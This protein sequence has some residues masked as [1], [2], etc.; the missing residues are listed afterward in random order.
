MKSSA[1][2]LLLLCCYLSNGQTQF[3]VTIP[4]QQDDQQDT[5]S[6]LSALAELKDEL[7]NTK[8]EMKSME[9]RLSV[10]ESQVEELKKTLEEQK[11]L[12]EGMKVAFS[13]SFHR[14]GGG[15]I[16]PFDVEIRLVFDNII[17]NIGNAYNPVTGA[18]TAPVRGVYQFDLHIHGEGSDSTPTAVD[19]LKNSMF[20][21]VAHGHQPD[22]R[23]STS[24]GVLLL[25]EVGD[26]ITLKMPS[27][28]S[29]YGDVYRVTTFSGHL[30]FLM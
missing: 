1:F 30:L 7:R 17:T 8:T 6:V 29:V 15:K 10:S 28:R 20:I 24:N 19:L 18:F 12:K 22:H 25:L 14:P 3:F 16:G 21:I 23:V 2:V 13:A 26:I 5:Q 27:R 11:Q 9:T 4:S